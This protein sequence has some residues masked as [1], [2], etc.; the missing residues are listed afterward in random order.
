MKLYLGHRI[1]HIVQPLTRKKNYVRPLALLPPL[2]VALSVLHTPSNV[3]TE[4]LLSV[5]KKKNKKQ[6]QTKK[7]KKNGKGKG[8]KS[9]FSEDVFFVAVRNGD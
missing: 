7:K 3:T 8:K 6:K 1:F 2:R 9:A 5:K 4:S